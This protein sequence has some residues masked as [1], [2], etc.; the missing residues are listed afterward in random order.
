MQRPDSRAARALCGSWPRLPPQLRCNVRLPWSSRLPLQ[1]GLEPCRP[2]GWKAGPGVHLLI[3]T[4][5]PPSVMKEN[6]E[7]VRVRPG[8]GAS[9]H[10][11][12]DPSGKAVGNEPFRALLGQ[13]K[14]QPRISGPPWLTDVSSTAQRGTTPLRV[15]QQLSSRGG[16]W[17][18]CQPPACSPRISQ[19]LPGT[20]D[21]VL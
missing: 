17:P 16:R 11:G 2:S 5:R 14:S 13:A 21:G 9:G 18:C 3:L 4:I 1:D 7:H 10:A 20:Q 6:K 15:T 8:N 12:G 19:G